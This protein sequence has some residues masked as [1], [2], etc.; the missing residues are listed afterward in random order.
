MYIKYILSRVGTTDLA[1]SA[2]ARRSHNT[3]V[4]GGG[5]Q[6][7]ACKLVEGCNGDVNVRRRSKSSFENQNLTIKLPTMASTKIYKASYVL[8]YLNV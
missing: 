6:D 1:T 4:F 8:Y 7:L 5:A 2:I 3:R